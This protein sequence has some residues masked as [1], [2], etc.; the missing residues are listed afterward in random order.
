MEKELTER[1]AKAKESKDP[2]ECLRVAEDLLAFS[3]KLVE[4]CDDSNV[5]EKLKE[6]DDVVDMIVVVEKAGD[7]P[8]TPLSAET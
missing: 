6:I 1:W 5:D 8:P 7:L 2:G 4:Q 3:F